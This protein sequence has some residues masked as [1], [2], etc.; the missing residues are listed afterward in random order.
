MKN[1]SNQNGKINKQIMI[2][3]ERIRD[4]REAKN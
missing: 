3:K 1:Q 4:V 2:H